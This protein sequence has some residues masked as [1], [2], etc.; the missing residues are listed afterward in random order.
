MSTARE[1][2]STPLACVP[3]AIPTADRPA[4]FALA[5]RLF[6]DAS[7]ERCALPDGYAF[8]FEPDALEQ[9]A[10]FVANERKCCPFLTF[11][12][13]LAAGGGPLW[14]QLTGPVGTREFLDAELAG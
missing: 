2:V 11:T 1:T 14:L 12:I 10:R 7:R 3:G 4:H 5:A 6:G 9:V 8:R 13:A